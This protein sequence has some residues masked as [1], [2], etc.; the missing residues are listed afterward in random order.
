MHQLCATEETKE[1]CIYKY[2]WMITNYSNITI[3]TF[4]TV[5]KN[6]LLSL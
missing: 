6:V 3:D 1:K 2:L 4:V 5:M